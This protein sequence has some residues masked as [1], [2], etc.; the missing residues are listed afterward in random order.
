MSRQESECRRQISLLEA[1]LLETG[2]KNSRRR[3]LLQ[4]QVCVIVSWAMGH[5]PR[6]VELMHYLARVLWRQPVQEMERA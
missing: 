1:R 6:Q 4:L 2:V 5:G 3:D